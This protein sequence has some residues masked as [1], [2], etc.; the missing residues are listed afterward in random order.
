MQSSMKILRLYK[1]L[2][3]LA[4]TEFKVVV[5][6]GE[7]FYTQ[8][9][10]PWKLRLHLCDASFLDIY[11]S[12][13]GKYSY[14]WDRRPEIDKIYRHD[15]APHMKWKNVSSFPKHFHSGSENVVLP[16]HISDDPEQALREFLNFILKH[17]LTEQ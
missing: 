15:N 14:H 3:D 4:S 6:S 1:N 16:S 10:E 13:N 8:S 5:E 9:N 2:L 7:I 17:I 12:V 11:Y